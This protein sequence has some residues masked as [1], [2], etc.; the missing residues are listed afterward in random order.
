V[1]LCPLP[2]IGEG[3]TPALVAVINA[4]VTSENM[5]PPTRRGGLSPAVVQWRESLP[6]DHP[7]QPALNR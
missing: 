2:F 6:D 1:T 4:N 5:A 3:A 7:M